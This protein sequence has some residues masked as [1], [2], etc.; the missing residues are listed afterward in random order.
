[1]LGLLFVVAGLAERYWKAS[2]RFRPVDIIRE[3]EKTILDELDLMR[4]AANASQL[5]RNWEGSRLLYVPEVYWD[6]NR[7]NVMVMERIYG[8]PVGNVAQLKAQ[9]VSMRQLGE[10]GVE[11]FFT[12]VFRYN[13]FH[14]DMHPGNIFVEPDGRYIA[15]DFFESDLP[16]VVTL[17]T[18]DRD[19]RVQGG[20]VGEP[21]VPAF[22]GR[23]RRGQ[24]A[25]PALRGLQDTAPPAPPH[26]R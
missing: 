21:G 13:F 10:Q 23:L 7:R 16:L 15:V 14:A 18:V 25:D 2:R 12:Q 8:T 22:L 26:V 1:M 11:I 19:H 3:Y 24:G 5:R 6:L 4:E 9:G 17:L 20:A